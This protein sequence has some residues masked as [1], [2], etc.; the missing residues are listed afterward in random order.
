MTGFMEVCGDGG[1]FR[2]AKEKKKAVRVG[3]MW[4]GIDKLCIYRQYI[5]ICICGDLGR[6]GSWIVWRWGVCCFEWVWKRVF[7]M[8]V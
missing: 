8:D 3:A 7:L 2:F 5:Y 6:G 4:C 1:I